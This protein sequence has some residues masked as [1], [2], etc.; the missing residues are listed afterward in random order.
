MIKGKVLNVVA[1]LGKD[2]AIRSI[3]P[4]CRGWFCQKTVPARL[5]AMKSEKR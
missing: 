4:I 3:G 5:L 2:S 1:K